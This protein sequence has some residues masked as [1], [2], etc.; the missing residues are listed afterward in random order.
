MILDRQN[1]SQEKHHLLQTLQKNGPYSRYNIFQ[2]MNRLQKLKQYSTDRNN[3]KTDTQKK[4]FL[5]YVQS[6]TDEISQI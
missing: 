3:T 1:F 5:N 2:A 6:K 4:P